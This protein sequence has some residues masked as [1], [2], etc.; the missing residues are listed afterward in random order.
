M[1]KMVAAAEEQ[2]FWTWTYSSALCGLC[3][4]VSYVLHAETVPA[5]VEQKHIVEHIAKLLAALLGTL[6]CY[7]LQCAV[8][9]LMLSKGVLRASLF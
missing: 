9:A 4:F 5:A 2:S 1:T 3:R 8:S 6:L 7:L